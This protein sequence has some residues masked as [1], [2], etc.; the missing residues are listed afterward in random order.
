ML[1]QMPYLLAWDSSSCHYSLTHIRSDQDVDMSALVSRLP[2]QDKSKFQ[3][4]DNVRIFAYDHMQRFVLKTAKKLEFFAVEHLPSG[5]RLVHLHSIKESNPFKKKAF[6]CQSEQPA[7]RTTNSG[8][9]I[10]AY[11]ASGTRAVEEALDVDYEDDLDLITVTMRKGCFMYSNRDGRFLRYVPLGSYW[12]PAGVNVAV[13]DCTSLVLLT[14]TEHRIGS[15]GDY[16]YRA[17]V[18]H[19]A[20]SP[21]ATLDDGL[22]ARNEAEVDAFDGENDSDFD[23]EDPL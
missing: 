12:A 10:P 19:E 5:R 15:G 8:R 1:Y 21:L 17:M 11:G 3:F 7:P 16:F 23:P 13:L 14:G 18:L 9:V 6:Y 20:E 4:E 22:L 2:A